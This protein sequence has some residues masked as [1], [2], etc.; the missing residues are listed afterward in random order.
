[1]KMAMAIP[2]NIY[3]GEFKIMANSLRKTTRK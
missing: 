3:C 1:M 2:N